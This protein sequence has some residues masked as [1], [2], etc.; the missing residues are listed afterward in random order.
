MVPFLPVAS[1][2]AKY[3]PPNVPLPMGSRIDISTDGGTIRRSMSVDE[4]GDD[5]DRI[6]EDD[7]ECRLDDGN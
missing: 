6:E 3:T 2:R 5:V 4:N 7:T 1:S